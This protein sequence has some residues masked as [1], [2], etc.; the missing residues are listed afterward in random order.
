MQDDKPVYPI[1]IAAELLEVHP[2]TLRLYEKYGLIHPR[3]R[4]KKRFFSNN[5]LQWIRCIREMIHEEG[6]NIS[7]IKR[8]LSLIPCWQ[9]KGCSEEE[10]KNCSAYYDKTEPCWELAKRICPE[11]FQVCKECRKYTEKEDKSI[12]EKTN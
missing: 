1:S 7:G 3:R 6:L 2:R 11:K 12:K 9:I 10:R 4:G 8:L 5:D